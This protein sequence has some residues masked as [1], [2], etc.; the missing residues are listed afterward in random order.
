[1]KNAIIFCTVFF[2]LFTTSLTAQIAKGNFLIGGNLDLQYHSGFSSGTLT[3]QFN[4]NIGYFFGNKL[5]LGLNGFINGTINNN[6]KSSN[7]MLSPYARYYFGVKEN[8]ALFTQLNAGVLYSNRKYLD[9]HTKSV[10]PYLGLGVGHT[11]FIN[12]HIGLETQLYAD[13]AFGKLNLGFKV[14]LQFYLGKKK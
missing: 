10:D 9:S 4:P 12:K 11:Y 5:A 8:A 6:L 2:L 14:G 1:M 13:N 3:G 7:D